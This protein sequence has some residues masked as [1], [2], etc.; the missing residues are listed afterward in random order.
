M[1]KHILYLASGNSRRFGKNKLLV[2]LGEKPLYRYGLDTLR[3]VIAEEGDCTLTVVSQYP[4]IRRAAEALNIPAV[5]SPESTLGISHTIRAGL[6]ALGQV[7]NE[8]F[9]LFVVADQPYLKADSVRRLLAQAHPGTETAR[10][11]AQKR[12]GNPVLFS[13][14]LLPELMA[15]EGDCGGSAVVKKHACTPVFIEDAA[16]FSDIDTPEDL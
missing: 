6:S 7:E 1:K 13:G 12:P 3:E 14:K 9:I 16:E 10:L 15:L 2:M 4:E 5:D 8:D 11:Y